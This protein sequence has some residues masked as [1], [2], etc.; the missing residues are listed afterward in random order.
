MSVLKKLQQVRFNLANVKLKKSGYNAFAKYNYFELDDFLPSAQV[1]MKNEG[2]TGVFNLDEKKAVLRIY[3]N[4]TMRKV[5]FSCNVREAQIKGAQAVQNL[6]GTITYLRRYLWVNALELTEKD[7]IDGL[8]QKSNKVAYEKGKETPPKPDNK[9]IDPSKLTVEQKLTDLGLYP[10]LA[11]AKAKVN[12]N[13]RGEFEFFEK[14][15]SEVRKQ[16]KNIDLRQFCG[17]MKLQPNTS[18]KLWNII[19]KE[20]LKDNVKS[21]IESSKKG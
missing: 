21:L 3:D 13:N 17:A 16:D 19:S 5:S 9:K 7:A 10:S 1:L 20:N 14:I 15:L 11:T 4:E 12:D 2:L 8:D 6:G 18:E